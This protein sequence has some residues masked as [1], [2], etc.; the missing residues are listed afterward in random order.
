MAG[1]TVRA[2]AAAAGD[3]PVDVVLEG[4]EAWAADGGEAWSQALM[5]QSRRVA[6]DAIARA[7]AAEAAGAQH[8][9]GLAQVGGLHCRL[10]ACVP[11][12]LCGPAR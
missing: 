8:Q 12:G 9:A 11:V 6:T 10:C 1:P 7:R 3:A 2:A 5:E 4:L